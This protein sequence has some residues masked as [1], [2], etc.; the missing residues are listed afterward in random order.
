MQRA[1]LADGRARLVIAVA[2]GHIEGGGQR[3]RLAV[4]HQHRAELKRLPGVFLLELVGHQALLAGAVRLRGEVAVLIDHQQVV[5]LDVL[6][7]QH[8][9]VADDHALAV[10]AAEVRVDGQHRIVAARDVAD[11][12]VDAAAEIVA[13]ERRAQ[14]AH[15]AELDIAHEVG[16]AVLFLLL[17]G[18]AEPVRLIGELARGIRLELAFRLRRDA[19]IGR[20]HRLLEDGLLILRIDR[21]RLGQLAFRLRGR[22]RQNLDGLFVLNLRPAL[23]AGL[24]VRHVAHRRAGVAQGQQHRRAQQRHQ[25]PVRARTNGRHIEIPLAEPARVLGARLLLRRQVISPRRGSPEGIQ[26]PRGQSAFRHP[27]SAFPHKE[28]ASIILPP[29]RHVK[30][31]RDLPGLHR[32]ETETGVRMLGQG[33]PLRIMPARRPRAA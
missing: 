32:A 2:A 15:V 25:R 13:R 24:H 33:L 31:L 26:P 1:L 22:A 9:A 18:D 4:F 17:D 28:S 20:G 11:R 8:L 29:P 19:G 12:L 27:R 6:P 3:R 14:L 10:I 16:H 30:R 5:L 23:K 21:Q 7:A